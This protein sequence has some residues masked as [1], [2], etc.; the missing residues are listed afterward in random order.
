[1]RAT[2]PRI[3]QRCAIKE[4]GERL[5]LM[6]ENETGLSVR[7]ILRHLCRNRRETRSLAQLGILLH[8]FCPFSPTFFDRCNNNNNNKKKKQK[9]RKKP[10]ASRD[11]NRRANYPSP[12][13]L[14]LSGSAGRDATPRFPAEVSVSLSARLTSNAGIVRSSASPPFCRCSATAG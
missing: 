3:G 1:M 4:K 6:R 13:F 5:Q 7:R 12:A 10:T 9:K 11:E 14:R 2:S 8:A